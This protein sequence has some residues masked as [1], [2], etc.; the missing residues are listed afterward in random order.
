[1]TEPNAPR[2]H[3]AITVDNPDS[4]PI[5]VPDQ[6]KMGGETNDR[7][8]LARLRGLRLWQ[9][10]PALLLVIALT[11]AWQILVGILD[12]SAVTLPPPSSIWSFTVTNREYIWSDTIVTAREALVA[13]L[14]SVLVGIPLGVLTHYS[15]PFRI[16]IYPL[17]VANQAFPKVAVGPLFIIWFGFG[18]KPIILLAILLAFF[19]ITLNAILGLASVTEDSRELCKIMGLSRT[20]AFRK[21]ILPQALPSIFA[22]LRLASVLI[23]VGVVVGEFLGTS[24]GLGYRVVNATSSANTPSLF[25]ALIVLSLLGLLIYGAVGLVERLCIPWYRSGSA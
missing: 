15:R 9:L 16:T 11:A 22:G 3:T 10:F 7:L 21:V 14:L 12:V 8:Y 18:T 5:A 6:T 20:K 25:S 17:L 24:E 2:H 1:M 4:P 13:F 19:P 23:V